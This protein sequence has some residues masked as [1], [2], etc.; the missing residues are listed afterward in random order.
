MRWTQRALIMSVAFGAVTMLTA[1]SSISMVITPNPAPP[2]SANKLKGDG[3]YIM[4]ANE[5]FGWIKF[6]TK[7]K[8]TT[9][10]TS[11]TATV[12]AGAK[13]WESTLQVVAGTYNPT[14][15]TL[16]YLDD[17]KM[18]KTSVIDST[19]DQIVK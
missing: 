2:P 15:A 16:H 3:S 9:Q 6:E 5:M 13:T 17:K 8:G 4:G 1:P 10:V 12:N 14:W 11:A 19:L 7:L 18:P